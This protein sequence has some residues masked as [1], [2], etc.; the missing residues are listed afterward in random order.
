L[1]ELK[2]EVDSGEVV[3]SATP[4]PA[5]GKKFLFVVTAAVVS[6]V[7]ITYLVMRPKEQGDNTAIEGTFTRLTSQSGQ[8]LSSSLSPNGDFVVYAS[9]VTGNWDI[10]LQRVGGENAMNLTENS[11]NDDT[12]PAFSPD[13][14]QIAFH[15]QRDGGGIFVM[16]ATGESVRRLTDL[17]CSPAWSPDGK[18]IGF[19]SNRSGSYEIWTIEPDGSGLQQL[20]DTPGQS[21]NFAVW[22]PDGSQMAYFNR[23]EGISYIFDPNKP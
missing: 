7:L 19:Y 22:S 20:T 8:E 13:G 18:K 12:H 6:A 4:A 9:A 17:G 15:S 2:Q 21:A 16:G 5:V 10:Y 3:E 23:S 11:T 14:E 1:E